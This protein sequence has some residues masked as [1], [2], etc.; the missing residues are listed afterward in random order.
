MTTTSILFSIK[1]DIYYQIERPGG[2]YL[3]LLSP[4]NAALCVCIFGFFISML[5]Y[6]HGREM[7]VLYAPYIA[8]MLTDH[9]VRRIVVYRC[10]RIHIQLNIVVTRSFQQPHYGFT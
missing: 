7:M 2:P 5:V 9:S 3:P 6:G 4:Y 1:C 10:P 8:D